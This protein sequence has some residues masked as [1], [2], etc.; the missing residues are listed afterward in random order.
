M[1]YACR[2]LVRQC[3]TLSGVKSMEIIK[4][5]VLASQNTLSHCYKTNKTMVFRE[6][7]AVYSQNHGNQ[8]NVLCEQTAGILDVFFSGLFNV[9]FALPRLTFSDAMM[10]EEQRIIKGLGGKWL[11]S[12]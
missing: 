12:N 8:L 11:W 7:I 1:L 2:L 9:P 10:I 5:T 4:N 3:F 6:G